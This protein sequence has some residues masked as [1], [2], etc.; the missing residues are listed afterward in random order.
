MRNLLLVVFAVV[1]VFSMNQV[2]RAQQ[3]ASADALIEVDVIGGLTITANQG[4][5]ISNLT[6]GYTY[7]LN[8]DPAS[9]VGG[10]TGGTNAVVPMINGTE[11][12]AA[13]DF[14]LATTS[15]TP[16]NVVVSFTLPAVLVANGVSGGS[17]TGGT[18]A[19]SFSPTSAVVIDAA[20]GTNGQIF[21]PNVPTTIPVGIAGCDVWLGC[22]V[23]VPA[24]SYP[25]SYFGIVVCTASITGL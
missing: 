14:A 12:G 3:N 15:G 24:T 8:P 23:T 25:D 19:I 4:I 1:L 16:E 18:L 2:V 13:A 17:G 22:T 21:N 11:T 9:D 10:F 7:T 20:T 6:P 5:T